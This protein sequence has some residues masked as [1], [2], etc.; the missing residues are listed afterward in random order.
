MRGLTVLVGVTLAVFCF[1]AISVI[2]TL[3]HNLTDA[4]LAVEP[5]MLSV[6]STMVSFAVSLRS[7]SALERF[8]EGRRAWS[9]IG[10]ACRN[11]ALLI[12]IHVPQTTL[13]ATELAELDKSGGMTIE[14]EQYEKAKALIEKRTIVNLLEAFAVSSKHYLR[15]EGGIYYDDLYHLVKMLPK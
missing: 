3:V 4:D 5:T 2:I 8:N 15:A 9:G 10:L 7:S 14:R 6:L 11:L 1:T 13:T 12:W